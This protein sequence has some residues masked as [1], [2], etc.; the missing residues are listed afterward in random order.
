VSENDAEEVNPA[1][2]SKVTF[3]QSPPD[4]NPESKVATAGSW[5][6]V[7]VNDVTS[8]ST[9]KRIDASEKSIGERVVRNADDKSGHSGGGKSS[10]AFL[11]YLSTDGAVREKDIDIQRG[12]GILNEGE[13]IENERYRHNMTTSSSSVPVGSYSRHPSS[14]SHSH[15]LPS[16]QPSR[17]DQSPH[18][19]SYNQYEQQQY[20][21]H[22]YEKQQYEQQQYQPPKN[23]GKGALVDVNEL[24]DS[25][26]SM[27]M[28]WYHSGYAT[29]RYQAL[30]E[31]NKKEMVRDNSEVPYRDNVTASPSEMKEDKRNGKG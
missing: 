28:A 6:P 16:Q 5:L 13:R 10:S 14:S 11:D 19:M 15:S 9:G 31:I 3:F 29:G 8:V 7:D 18:N 27:L 24:E 23:G 20:E 25:F 1:K 2:N 4:L 12:N 21:Q 30:L 26:N 17:Y 22:Q